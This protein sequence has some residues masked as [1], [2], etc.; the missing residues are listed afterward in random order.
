MVSL[1]SLSGTHHAS[2]DPGSILP[3]SKNSPCSRIQAIYTLL[4]PRP[5]TGDFLIAFPLFFP[6]DNPGR[7]QQ[8]IYSTTT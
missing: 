7:E 8:A 2:Q 6:W 5:V 4:G 1:K 3:S